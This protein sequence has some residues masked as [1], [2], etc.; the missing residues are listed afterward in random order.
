MHP[1]YGYYRSGNPIGAKGDFITSPEVSQVFG[2]LLGLSLAVC[3]MDQGCPDKICLIEA[4]PG[5]GTLLTD[6][7]R[8]TRGVAGFHQAFERR[9][10][11][12]EANPDLRRQQAKQLSGREPV[13]IDNIREAPELP[14]FLVA[15]EFLDCLPVHVFKRTDGG[16]QERFVTAHRSGLTFTHGKPAPGSPTPEPDTGIDDIPPGSTVEVSPSMQEFAETVGYHISRN[17]GGAILVDYGDWGLVGSSLQA[18]RNHRKSDP[19]ADPGG[20]DLTAHVDFRA[21]ARSAGRHA[22]V[23]GMV[24]QG[25]LLE[26]L[27]ITARARILARGLASDAFQSHMAAHRRLVHPDAMGALFKAICIVPKGAPFPPG[28]SE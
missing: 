3:W 13:W 1:Q 15:N 14:L 9:I 4:G 21:L 11:L 23:S 20:T 5:R 19:L 27:G 2:E 16:W 18:V 24:P 22:Q 10:H 17:G 12:I 8:A 6:L 25:I 26:R 7:V 28:F